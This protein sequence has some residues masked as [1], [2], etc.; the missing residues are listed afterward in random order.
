MKQATSV[1]AELEDLKVDINVLAPY[2]A[3]PRNGD[4]EALVKSLKKHG[5]YRP[6]VVRKGT[7]EI[8]AG[9]HT[10]A[11]A[12][13]LG[14]KH[15]AVTYHDCDAEADRLND[16][17]KG[18]KGW[19]ILS[20]DQVAAM[21]VLADNRHNDLAKYDEGLL[22]ELLEGMPT[23]EGTGYGQ[24]DLDILKRR[25]EAMGDAPFNTDG[26]WDGMPGFDQGDARGAARVVVHFATEE[27]CEEFFAL[28]GRERK[29]VMW[30]PESDGAD[31]GG[32]SPD[33]KVVA[34]AE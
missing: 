6:I 30:W 23:L 31:L 2:A 24:T 9:N 4:L 28:I 22:A 21:I 12:M 26:S 33:A 20:G 16:A 29:S 10:Y 17:N 14:W 25:L 19:T 5:Q 1:P 32:Y 3:N 7:N 11:A 8:L 18:D 34:V 13:E 27:D 15:I